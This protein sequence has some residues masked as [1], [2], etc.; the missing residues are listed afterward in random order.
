MLKLLIHFTSFDKTL[1]FKV[2]GISR[3]EKKYNMASCV[4]CFYYVLCCMGR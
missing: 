4:L 3:D 2:L 1:N